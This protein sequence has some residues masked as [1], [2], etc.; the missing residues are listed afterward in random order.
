[1][2]ARRV[3]GRSRIHAALHVAMLAAIE[4]TFNSAPHGVE[5]EKG[6]EHRQPDP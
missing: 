5:T 6:L 2:T 4:A 3:R 1:M